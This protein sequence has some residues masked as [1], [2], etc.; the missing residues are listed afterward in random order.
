MNISAIRF[1]F[2]VAAST[3]ACVAAGASDMSLPNFAK[4]APGLYRG[5]APTPEGL[6]RVKQMGVTTVIDLRIAPKTV[7]KEKMLVESL[8]M[9]FVNLPMGSDPP[10]LAQVSTFLAVTSA[11][12]QHPVF[13][14]CQHGADRTGCMFGIYREV[15]DKWPYAKTYTEMRQYGFK[16]Y[17]TKLDDAVKKR[18]SS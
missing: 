18:A 17:Y 7:V 14:H 5:A 8:G 11:A 12:G 1:S 9:K 16:P 6:V 10:T 13:V 4:V 2:A 3:I 15:H